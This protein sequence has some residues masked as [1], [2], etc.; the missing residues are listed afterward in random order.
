MFSIITINYVVETDLGVFD[1]WQDRRWTLFLRLHNN[2]PE[3]KIRKGTFLYSAV[4]SPW[5]YT[6]QDSILRSLHILADLFIPMTSQLLW[7]VFIHAA[8]TA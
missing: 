1:R 7:E 2:R 4:S 5:D 6:K 8:I 3:S